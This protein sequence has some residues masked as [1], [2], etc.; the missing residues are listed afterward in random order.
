MAKGGNPCLKKQLLSKS[1]RIKEKLNLYDI[2]RIRNPKAKQYTFTQQHFSGFIQR[3]LDYIFV[4]QNFHEITMHKEIL[5]A[6]ST[7]HSPALCSLQ[8][9]N[10]C[11]KG[12]VLWKF[13][14]SLVCNEEYVLRL[15]EFINK[16][17]G[18]LNHSNQFC[19]QVK[20]E[21]LKYE[22]GFMIKFWKDLAKAKKSKQYS[23]E[24]KLKLLESN[25]NCDINSVEHIKCK[26]QLEE[27][28]HDIADS[29]K[30]RSKCQ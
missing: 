2:W 6:I 11:Q 15:K 4:S 1:L 5:N 18:E 14:N 23:L 25:L 8:S 16:V 27:I 22:I 21:L 3:R 29:I 30:V 10:Q 9:L 19:D 12:P 7:D 13:N 26:N 20:W 24:N 28:Y 17:M